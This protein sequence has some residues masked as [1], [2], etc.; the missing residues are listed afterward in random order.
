MSEMH[1]HATQKSKIYVSCGKWMNVHEHARWSENEAFNIY[2][3]L[4]WFLPVGGC[5]NSFFDTFSIFRCD[6]N[7]VTWDGK[8]KTEKS[9]V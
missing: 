3:L 9:L 4:V 6:D 2:F 8:S 1:M 7:D 5:V